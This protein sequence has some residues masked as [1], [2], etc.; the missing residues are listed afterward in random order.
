MHLQHTHKHTHT[1]IHSHTA[2]HTHTQ[3][4]THTATHT[5]NE[6]L[7]PLWKY[8]LELE[9]CTLHNNTNNNNSSV[10]LQHYTLIKI[11]NSKRDT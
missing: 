4:H 6:E 2:T 5:E 11:T 7:F 10:C 8:G 3:K 1:H 9:S